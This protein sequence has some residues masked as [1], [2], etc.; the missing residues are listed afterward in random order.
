[1]K[2]LTKFGHC[3]SFIATASLVQLSSNVYAQESANAELDSC[4]RNEQ[5]VTTAKGV[6]AGAIAGLSAMFVAH[7]SNDAVK[8]A[9]I[10][11]AVGG[12]AGFATAYY[13]AVDTCYRKNPSWKPESKLERTQSYEELKKKIKYKP[14]QGIVARAESVD[15]GSPVKADSQAQ[16]NSTFY[17]MTPDG[18]ETNI[19]VE[20]KLF[21]V[22]DGKEEQVVFPGD[23][24][25]AYT[26]AGGEQR[27]TVHI[28][29]AKDT[30]SGTV[31]RVE[32]DVAAAGMPP[33]IASKTFTVTE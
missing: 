30:K 9:L 10:G 22:T 17:V 29:I 23:A 21:V 3:F 4:V 25:Q 33:S 26:V 15:V 19:T 13:T 27:D 7:K 8:G 14:S 12:V 20:R 28:P 16:M 5:I 1:M 6:G 24:T 32:F 2:S 18:A 31:Y 11:A